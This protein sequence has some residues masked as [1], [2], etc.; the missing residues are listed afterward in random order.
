MLTSSRRT[1]L[2]YMHAAPAPMLE[3][4]IRLG[5]SPNRLDSAGNLPLHC[6]AL[7]GNDDAVRYL[8]SV[9]LDASDSSESEDLPFPSSAEPS[10]DLP[11][12]VPAAVP[13]SPIPV[14]SLALSAPLAPLLNTEVKC[15]STGPLAVTPAVI[16]RSGMCETLTFC[17]TLFV[18]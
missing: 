2:H 18:L 11:L 16:S 14:P 4:L 13:L 10:A 3:Q 7:A 9:L 12:P 1:P 5:F 8:L 17:R 6:A 15:V